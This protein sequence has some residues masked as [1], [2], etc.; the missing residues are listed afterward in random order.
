MRIVRSLADGARLQ[1][2]D[3]LVARTTDPGWTP[4]FLR[5]GAVVLELGGM[6]SHAAVVARELGV[7]AVVNVEGACS[8]LHDGQVVLV[9]GSRGIVWSP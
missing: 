8:R 9:D 7:P 5:A 6:L 4:L 1:P 2:G 3:I